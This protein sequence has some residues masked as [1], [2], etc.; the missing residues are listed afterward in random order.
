MRAIGDGVGATLGILGDCSRAVEERLRERYDAADVLL[1]NSGTSALILALKSLLPPGAT[2][3]L[4]GYACID[5]TAAAVGAGVRVRLYDLNPRTLSPDLDSVSTIMKRGVDAIVVAHLYGYPAD[6]SAVQDLAGEQGVMVIEDA[7]Q[8]AG[9][10]YFGAPLGSLADVS[11]LS[12][13]RGKGTTAGSG[14]AL[15]VGTSPLAERVA[16]VRAELGRASRGGREIIKLTAQKILSH[17]SLYRLPAS[18]PPLR[19]GEM[20][21]HAPRLPLRMSATGCAV[22]RRTLELEGLELE[23][24]RGNARELLLRMRGQR[25]LTPI[26]SIAGGEPG[27][28]RFAFLDSAGT[29]LPNKTLGALRG[30]PLTLEQHAELRPHLLFGEKA[31]KGSEVLRDRLYVAP[32]HSRLDHQTV[33]ALGDWFADVP[34]A[35]QPMAAV[36]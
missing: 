35:M 1:T 11:I 17:P 33:D 28:L 27:Y 18:I 13:G 22:L 14:G 31:G 26:Y 15:L 25:G 30:Y 8:A 36:S 24:R 29:R 2:V 4:P 5:L 6:V 20:V 7:A 19:L 34:A 3:A 32:T 9:G 12:F 21:Y 10:K 23:H 16:R